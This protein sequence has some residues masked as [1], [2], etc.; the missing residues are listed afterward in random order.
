[1]PLRAVVADIERLR[2]GSQRPARGPGLQIMVS[3]SI[4]FGRTWAVWQPGQVTE[5]APHVAT[6]HD[7]IH[8]CGEHTG[9]RQSGHGR[10]DGIRGTGRTRSRR[11][12][13]YTQI[14]PTGIER[15]C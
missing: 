4:F 6:P 12:D 11:Q 3:R 14:S 8:F 10:R 9:A 13:G 7:R 1:M 2:P 5:L 15:C